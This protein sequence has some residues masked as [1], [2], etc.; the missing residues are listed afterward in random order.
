MSKRR[1]LLIILVLIV[2]VGVFFVIR[3]YTDNGSEHTQYTEDGKLI[4]TVSMYNNSTFPQWRAY[5][6][7]QCPDVYINWENNLN[8][9]S[10]VLYKAR[11]E[12]RTPLNA[13][14]GYLT[15]ADDTDRK[16]T[17]LNSSHT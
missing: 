1:W 3:H 4:V 11:H 2:S 12:I 9:A 10:N 6:E 17:R 14:L 5:V 8:A 13:V 15:I 16:S 7:K